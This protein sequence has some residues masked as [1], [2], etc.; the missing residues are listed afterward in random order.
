MTFFSVRAVPNLVKVVVSAV[1]FSCVPFDPLY[2]RC[3]GRPGVCISRTLF[4][5]G[6]DNC[7]LA[8]DEQGCESDAEDKYTQVAITIV[9]DRSG[10]AEAVA[11]AITS[12]III[13]LLAIVYIW[14]YRIV[15][16]RKSQSR[17]LRK[18]LGMGENEAPEEHDET[19]ALLAW[20][21][22]TQWLPYMDKRPNA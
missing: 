21:L 1:R 16:K 4:C 10:T 11:C 7:G 18:M 17:C 9:D 14:R 13:S 2:R 22:S 12:L 5:D 6:E 8:T 20:T 19:V 3:E 15:Q